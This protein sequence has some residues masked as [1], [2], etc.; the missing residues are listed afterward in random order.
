M[1]STSD[2]ELE[3]ESFGAGDRGLDVSYVGGCYDRDGFTCRVVEVTEVTDVVVEDC[4]ETRVLLSVCEVL[5]WE[6][7]I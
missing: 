4:E 7:W 3:A 5:Y 2:T 6:I 1:A